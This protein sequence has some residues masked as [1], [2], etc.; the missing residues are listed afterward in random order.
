M[1]LSVTL[2]DI[3]GSD[4]KKL[5]ARLRLDT[6][7][8]FKFDKSMSLKHDQVMFYLCQAW[9]YNVNDAYLLHF[10]KVKAWPLYMM[11]SAGFRFLPKKM[12]IY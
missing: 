2:T 1:S 5:I 9:L 8:E 10:L 6:I 12:I 11:N 7:S 4:V 3:S